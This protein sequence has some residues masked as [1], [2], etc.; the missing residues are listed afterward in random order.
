[1]IRPTPPCIL[2]EIPTSCN[3]TSQPAHSPRIKTMR[4]NPHLRSPLTLGSVAQ[5]LGD[6]CNGVA[7]TLAR[8]CHDVACRVGD[9]A[10][11]LA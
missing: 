10:Y 4:H 9:G 2:D 6:A 1:M 8:R 3:T 5:A 11:A 7:N